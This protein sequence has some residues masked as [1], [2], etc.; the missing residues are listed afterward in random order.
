MGRLPL[1]AASGGEALLGQ[2]G[3]MWRESTW[4]KVAERIGILKAA[5][6]VLG[7]NA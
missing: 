7:K 4:G 5:Y 3:S 1:G 2:W 6:W